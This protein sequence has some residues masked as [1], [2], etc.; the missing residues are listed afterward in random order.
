MAVCSTGSTQFD[1]VYLTQCRSVCKD[2]IHA[3]GECPLYEK[4]EIMYM[5]DAVE[6]RLNHGLSKR[7]R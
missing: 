3:V 7:R 6:R 2:R 1:V 4:K 5:K